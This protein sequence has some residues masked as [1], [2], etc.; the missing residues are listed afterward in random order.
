MTKTTLAS[1][2]AIALGMGALGSHAGDAPATPTPAKSAAPAAAAPST[3]SASL[4][5]VAES[6]GYKP[7]QQNGH[8]VYC[9]KAPAANS[10]LNETVCI[11]QDQVATVVNRSSGYQQSIEEL[12]RT[13]LTEHAVV[14]PGGPGGGNMGRQN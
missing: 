3:D 11:T 1:F 2:L 4:T 13:F 10:R 12:Q 14:E 9:R 8:T 6:A 7:K 5:K